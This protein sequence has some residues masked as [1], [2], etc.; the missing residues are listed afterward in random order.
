MNPFRYGQIVSKNHYCHRPEL[1]MQLKK[2][3]ISGQNTYIEGERRAGKTSLIFETTRKIRSK[4]IIYVDLLEVKTVEDIFKRF[5][6]GI[7]KAKSVGHLFQNIIKRASTLR[8]VMTFDP[9]NGLPSISIDTTLELKPESLEGILDLFSEKEFHNA[10]VVI[11]EFQDIVNLKNSSQVLAVMRSKVQ[12]YQEIPFVF[13]GS[14]RSTINKIFTDHDSP[15]F[16]SAL[17]LEVGAIEDSNFSKFIS[18]KFKDSK[19]KINQD[20]I[21]RIFDICKRNPGDIQQ[22]CYALCN[23]TEEGEQISVETINRTLIHI[24]AQERKGYESNL[25]RL[26]SIQLKCLIAVAKRGGKNTSSKEF[27]VHS[28]VTQPTTIKKA[29]T[30]LV[31]LKILFTTDGE[32][33]FI[34]PFFAGWLIHKNL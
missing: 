12:F 16:K 29:L 2:Y 11:D 7:V 1:E 22:L 18:S 6:N 21:N 23:V 10:I 28:G 34:N 3:L 31:E 27:I 17:P 32:Y 30:R 15:F 4:W 9:F 25:A 8:P 19:I 5:L 14:I 24:F 20:I 13:C 26:T 33:R